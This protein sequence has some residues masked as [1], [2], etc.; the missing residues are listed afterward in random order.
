MKYS[1]HLEGFEG[2]KIEVDI[3]FWS[4]PK[5]LVNG[6]PAS[7]GVKRGE[8]LLQRND[9]RQ[10]TATWKPQALGFDVPQLV[11]D[12]KP[13]NLVEPLKWYQWLWGGWPV[14]LIF[15]GGLLGALAGVIGFSINAKIFRSELNDAMKYVASGI[16]AILA[17]AA[18]FVAAVI[19][20]LVMGS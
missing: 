8:L 19:F 4:G 1:T 18:Y 7:K 6:E 15:V 17:V 14:T 2:Q 9:G 13:V 11:V 3:G 10:V 16:V 5:L 12:G 20:S